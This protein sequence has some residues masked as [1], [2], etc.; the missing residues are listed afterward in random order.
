MKMKPLTC[1]MCGSND[2]IKQ[3]GLFVCQICGTK[4][5]VEEARKM[6]IEG[7]VDVSGSTVKIDNSKTVEN[8]INIAQSSYNV[9]NYAEAEAYCN[10]ALENDLENYV[11]WALKGKA[12]G[13]QSTPVFPRIEESTKCFMKAIDYAPDEMVLSYKSLLSEEICWITTS[14]VSMSCNNFINNPCT[15]NAN[16]I[17]NLARSS[18]TNSAQLFAIC[19]VDASEYNVSIASLLDNAVTNAWSGIVN[20]YHGMNRYPNRWALQTFQTDCYNCMML[21][22]NAIEIDMNTTANSVKRYQTL[23]WL[24]KQMVRAGCWKYTNT[25]EVD[26]YPSDEW[27]EKYIDLIMIYHEKI[28]EI[29]PDYQIPKRPKIRQIIKDEV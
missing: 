26:D 28:K 14:V 9:K 27:R 18:I 2:V 11:A 12:A 24:S 1:E 13:W 25:W 3:E 16:I 6:M 22:K 17:I 20:R 21:K 23:I 10:K 5:S 29:D 7:P 15:E 19:K 8:Y 4:Y